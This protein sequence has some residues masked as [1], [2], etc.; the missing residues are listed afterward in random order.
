MCTKNIEHQRCYNRLMNVYLFSLASFIVSMHPLMIRLHNRVA[1][2]W[3]HKATVEVKLNHIVRLSELGRHG[4]AYIDRHPIALA[5][6]LSNSVVDKSQALGLNF[7][8]VPFKVAVR[9][10]SPV[11]VEHVLQS[12][13]KPAERFLNQFVPGVFLHNELNIVEVPIARL[14]DCVADPIAFW[15]NS[16]LDRHS[17][18]LDFHVVEVTRNKPEARSFA[19]ESDVHINAAHFKQESVFGPR[20][21]TKAFRS[22]GYVVYSVPLQLKVI[23]T[24]E[25]LRMKFSKLLLA[26]N[27][28]MGVQGR[29][30]LEVVVERL[31]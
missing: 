30:E 12:R 7:G 3:V 13:E 24:S 4:H 23:I 6:H 31:N 25:A 29:S 17:K 10:V 9:V 18:V 26:D 21:E 22:E 27:L 2:F 11:L 1:L 19:L 20:F 16:E 5:D 28:L 15:Y 14:F 8:I